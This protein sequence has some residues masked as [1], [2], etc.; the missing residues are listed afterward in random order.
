ML[1]SVEAQDI[2]Q[3]YN[4]YRPPGRVFLNKITWNFSAGYGYTQYSHNLEGFWLYQAQNQLFVRQQL[5][6]ETN[7]PQYIQG[8][9]NWLNN[10]DQ[11]PLAQTEI[12]TDIPWRYLPN[13]IN[14]PELI[15]VPYANG[16]TV[17]W[18]G[19]ANSIPITAGFHVEFKNLKIG[20]GYTFEPQWVYDLKTVNKE[21]GI[22]NYQPNFD[23]TAFHRA[24][25][26]LGYRFYEYW[27]YAAVADLQVGKLWYGQVFNPTQTQGTIN[28]NLG[29]TLEHHWSEY[30]AL[31]LRPSFDYK[32]YT[33][34]LPD[35]SFILHQHNSFHLQFG[36]SMK[37]PEIPRSPIDADHVQLKHV[38]TDP[39]TGRLMEVRG[40]PFWKKQNPK[41]GENHRK[42]WRYKWRN[43]R[44]LHPY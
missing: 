14:N 8:F 18:K 10:P 36:V 32:R 33:M 26:V 17:F 28:F 11:G 40:Q 41:V 42:L 13:P 3:M 15:G 4:I 27:D 30:F 38:I 31:T 9:G 29:L 25:G 37:I 35:N 12:N 1:I 34:T 20:A 2:Y 6:E 21:S 24:F 19:D 16:D 39:A 7:I 23:Y 5:P 43:K 22:P 44:K